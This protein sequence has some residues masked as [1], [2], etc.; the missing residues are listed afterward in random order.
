VADVV[1]DEAAPK[2]KLG[3]LTKDEVAAL[4]AKG[5][6]AAIVP[7][8]SVEPHG[9]HLPL[10]TDTIISA[11]AAELAAIALEARG[12]A[13]V[14]APS[15]PYGVTDFAAG[16]AGAV[17]LPAKALT[18]VLRALAEALLR[19]G[20]AHV[21]FVNNHLEP[22]Q[23]AAVRA[24]VGG[25]PKGRGSVAC[26][27][28]RRWA[29][30]LSAEFKSGACHAGRYETS[31]V[32]ATRPELVRARAGLAE[33]PISLSDGIRAGKRTFAEMGMDDAYAGAPA[34][35]SAEEGAE[36]YLL[37]AEMVVTEVA[38]AMASIG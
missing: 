9:P 3:E 29:R 16:F 35:A 4:F 21:S 32:L 17:S 19:A 34:L 2:R 33:A 37:L 18:A 23:D 15:L 24:A 26:P 25:L 27:L 22:A 31:L 10:E 5:P 8:G 7:V 36:Q 30:T 6:V 14:V 28:T 11:R 12:I 20:F 1:P 38:E 13:A